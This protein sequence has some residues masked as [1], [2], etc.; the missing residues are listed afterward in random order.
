MEIFQAI[1]LGIVEG[2]TEFLPISSTGHLIVAQDAIGYY[3]TS[4]IFTVVIQMGA[5]SAVIWFYRLNLINLVKGLF[6][7]DKLARAFWV[8]WILATIPAGIAGLFFDA[9]LEAYA[10]TTTVAIA[11]IVGGIVIWFIET[12][13]RAKPSKEANLDKITIKQALLIGCYQVIALIPGVSR[14]GA[15]IIGGLLSGLDRVTATAFSF[16]L[17]IP[18]LLMAGTYKLITGDLTT[19]E[20]GAPALIV[21]VFVSF[22]TALIVIKWLLSYVSRHD[23]KIFAYY[24]IF[25]GFLLL[26]LVAFGVLG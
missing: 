14:S 7:G 20:G 23:F 10:I 4:K 16:Y 12:Y 25:F 26:V 13:H 2:L 15:T 11:S 8:V 19:V 18:I 21:G 22:I 3:D 1:I 5:I 9:K 24:R 6:N 17:G